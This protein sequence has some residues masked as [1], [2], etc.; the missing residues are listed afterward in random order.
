MDDDYLQNTSDEI[1]DIDM[2]REEQP[3]RDILKI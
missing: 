1:F 2:V 3:M